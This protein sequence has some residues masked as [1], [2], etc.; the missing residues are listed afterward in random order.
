MSLYKDN[1]GRG[2]IWTCSFL[3]FALSLL[4][5]TQGCSFLFSLFKF[6]SMIF[7]FIFIVLCWY[8]SLGH[9]FCFFTLFLNTIHFICFSVFSLYF[10]VLLSYLFHFVLFLILSLSLYPLTCFNILL[11]LLHLSSF[12]FSFFYLPNSPF[13]PLPNFLFAS[14][15]PNSPFASSTLP[16]LFTLPM[17][18]FSPFSS[19]PF[20]NLLFLSP[21][22]HF[23]LSLFV[24]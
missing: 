9:Q 4:L 7:L 15:L 24:S 17:F 16:L 3:T 14:S 6:P 10:F 12:W 8:F 1:E 21:F 13:S 22:F 5:I 20:S 11:F 2:I 19:Y 18:S 23:F